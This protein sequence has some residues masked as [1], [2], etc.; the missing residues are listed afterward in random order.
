MESLL[1]DLRYSARQLAR[2]R[3]FTAVAVLSLALGIGANST[4]FSV[5]NAF[6][7]QRVTAS[8]PDELVR[9]YRGHHSP[10]SYKEYAFY[11]DN[12][13]VFSHFIT[14]RMMNVGM[15]TTGE[16]EKRTA[17]LVNGEYF[18]ALG[19]APAAGHFFNIE[20]DRLDRS[21]QVAVISYRFWQR[22]FAGDAGVI[23]QTVRLNNHPFK[24]IGVG[25]EGFE[26]SVFPW[27]PDVFV[28]FTE[29]STLLN[30]PLDEW[31]GSLYTT[32]RLKPGVSRSAAE[33]E[34]QT[35]TARLIAL[36]PEGRR[37]MTVRL[38][39]VRGVNAEL[40]TPAMAAAAL[41]LTV[42]GL[43]LLIACANIAN[44]LLA[45]ATT[46]RREISIRIAIG[47]SRARLV[48]QLLTESVLLALL[49]GGIGFL[50]AL[51]STD[52]F[53]VFLSPE[54]PVAV[55]LTPDRTVLLFTLLLS[56]VTGVLFGL[57]PALRASSPD[58]VSAIKDEASAQGYRRSRLRNSLVI[59]QV[60]LCMVLLIGASLFVRSLSKAKVI[61]P[62]FEPSN[63][64]VLQL[65]PGLQQY[66][67]AR[68]KQFYR[69]LLQN[70]EA[71]PGVERA[72][73]AELVPLAFSNMET[74][75]WIE[76][77]APRAP[78][79]RISTYFNRVG[80]GYFSVIK[81]PLVRGRE[82]T[83]QDREGAPRV[84]VI[85]EEF[86]RRFWPGQD[87]LGK[88]VSW[89]GPEGP[90]IEVVGIARNA[91]YNTLGET[92]PAFQYLPVEQSFRTEQ[93]LHVR[94]SGNPTAS[95]KAIRGVV[96]TLDPSLPVGNP[97]L[98]SDEMSASL[99]PAQAGASVLGAFGL[100]ALLLGAVGIYGV[101]SYAVAQRT[102]ELGIRTALGAQRTDL[103]RMVLRESMKLVSAGLVI[104]L[105]L[106]LGIGRALTGLLYGVSAADPVTF[107]TTP[108]ILA[109][110][111]LLASWV[112]AR[113][114][115]RADPMVALRSE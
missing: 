94:T 111:A 25:P 88:R 79:Q 19:L 53:N 32:A 42:V 114:A 3:G 71:L 69:Q 83:D 39:H 44:L 61:D 85:N 57:V 7:I 65:D 90:W 68:G 33:A 38:D 45:R 16:S 36:D 89:S 11:R 64:A 67:D 66:D 31:G 20:K 24:V 28:P 9:V 48:R 73:V 40:R 8:H 13:S 113:R 95:L 82:F 23:G 47:A 105:V 27:N 56:V 110:I 76:G 49:G 63:V 86:A 30:T 5:A 104:G 74:T 107:V 62:G 41:L 4:I 35:L 81:M 26:S 96:Q 87:A 1:Q 78:G 102:R 22:R 72:T 46:R 112:P 58:L 70:V 21:E 12:N 91:K 93:Y 80:P 50:L 92:T 109:A 52:L 15:T 18:T 54:L 34:L 2:S 14:E 84:T 100:L 101:T 10:L 99:I 59:A 103:M 51:W 115:T 60:T 43:V 17:A 6:L 37:N 108:L 75:L 55:D 98:M 106:A 97:K 29:S 77:E